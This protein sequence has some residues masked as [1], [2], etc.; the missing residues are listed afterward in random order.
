MAFLLANQYNITKPG[1]DEK[2]FLFRLFVG[3]KT[4]SGLMKTLV[5]KTAL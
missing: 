2:R 3:M 5:M 4:A 1:E